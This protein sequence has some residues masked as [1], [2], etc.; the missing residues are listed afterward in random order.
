[1]TGKNDIGFGIGKDSKT[2]SPVLGLYDKL[3]IFSLKPD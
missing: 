2:S 3:N 1:M